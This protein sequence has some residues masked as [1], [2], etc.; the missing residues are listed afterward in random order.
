MGSAALYEGALPI[1]DAVHLLVQTPHLFNQVRWQLFIALQPSR[2][3]SARP[4]GIECSFVTP[5][6]IVE[7]A[8]FVL[9][10]ST[11]AQ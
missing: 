4:G 3:P 9:F 7:P 2:V 6:I 10:R 5:A 8:L 11:R 1:G